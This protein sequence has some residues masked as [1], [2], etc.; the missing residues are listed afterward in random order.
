MGNLFI[1]NF[2]QIQK[3]TNNF[4]N[5]YHHKVKKFVD[6][7]ELAQETLICVHKAF[8]NMDVDIK[9]TEEIKRTSNYKTPLFIQEMKKDQIYGD[10]R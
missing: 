10:V 6:K 2:E 7:D 4:S 8:Q 3:I 1:D 9:F 5:I